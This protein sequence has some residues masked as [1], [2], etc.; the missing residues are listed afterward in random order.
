MK[1]INLI[2]DTK[3]ADVC[4]PAHGL[5][6]YIETRAHK[7]LVDLGPSEETLS[8][9]E[10]LGIDIAGVDTVVLSHGH[11]DHSGGIMP[12]VHI[13]LDHPAGH[14]QVFGIDVHQPE[15]RIAQRVECQDIP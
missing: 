14:F 4:A 9:A 1:I 2:E 15:F 13:A 12:F 8:N 5:S 10:K 11:Y 7:L 6:F 3:G